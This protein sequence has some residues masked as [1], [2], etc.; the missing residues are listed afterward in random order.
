MT[1]CYVTRPWPTMECGHRDGY[2]FLSS[3]RISPDVC[4]AKTLSSWLVWKRKPR[5]EGPGARSRGQPLDKTSQGLRP[6]RICV[7]PKL[8]E[9]PGEGPGLAD[10]RGSLR[11]THRA[12]A[13][14]GQRAWE[15]VLWAQE[16]LPWVAADNPTLLSSVAQ[17]CGTFS[18]FLA[19]SVTENQRQSEPL[20]C[21]WT[22]RL[23]FHG[24]D[25]RPGPLN[26]IC[27]DEGDNRHRK[28]RVWRLPSRERPADGF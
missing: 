20:L 9:L 22:P 28:Q 25:M 18:G 19:P 15:T 26:Q 17:H 1:A 11:V 16:A 3:C 13:D 4:P 23:C 21:G 12:L 10:P 14:P 6:L 5:P 27:A 7:L 8:R 24:A 2:S